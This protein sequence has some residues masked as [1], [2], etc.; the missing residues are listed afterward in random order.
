[1]PTQDPLDP[2]RTIR[3]LV[4]G[5]PPKKGTER[6]M[7]SKPQEIHRVISLRTRAPC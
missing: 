5:L 2:T 4:P 7:W 3:L 6:S 1:M